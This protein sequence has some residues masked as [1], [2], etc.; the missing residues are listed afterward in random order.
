[1]QIFKIWQ[2]L[3]SRAIFLS[4]FLAPKVLCHPWLQYILHFS[5]TFKISIIVKLSNEY[6]QIHGDIN[7]NTINLHQL[8]VDI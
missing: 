5:P 4:K 7:E 1:M 8:L 6:L 3:G 2:I